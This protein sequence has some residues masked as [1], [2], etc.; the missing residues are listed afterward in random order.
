MSLL[1]L[2]ELVPATSVPRQAVEAGRPMRL[3]DAGASCSDT[4]REWPEDGRPNRYIWFMSPSTAEVDEDSD[5]ST[6]GPTI[7]EPKPVGVP[8]DNGLDVDD[9]PKV[10][11]RLAGA[12][13]GPS[14]INVLD[15]LTG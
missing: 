6:G 3:S 13:G 4:D 9:S 15:G 10:S 12:R 7:T 2:V 1:P 5:R 11:L 14:G 8:D